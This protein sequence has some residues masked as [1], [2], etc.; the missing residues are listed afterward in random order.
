MT[1]KKIYKQKCYNMDDRILPYSSIHVDDM[2][3]FLLPCPIPLECLM[4]LCFAVNQKF[5]RRL[6]FGAAVLW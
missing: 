6:Y 3:F 1:L 2:V 4:S 5:S